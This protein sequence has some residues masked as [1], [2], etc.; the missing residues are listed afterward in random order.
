MRT[1]G[2]LGR[3]AYLWGVLFA[4]ALSCSTLAQ[5]ILGPDQMDPCERATF[6]ITVTNQ[7]A[8]QD[9][10]LVRITRSYTESGVLY[11][12]GSTTILLH[13][14]TELTADP[15]AS[16]WDIDALLGSAYTLPPA[17][18]ITIAYDLETS[19]AAV[20][21]TEQ[22]TV[23]YED[24][25][26]P[27]VSLQGVSSTSIEI[28]P[29]AVT[30]TKSPSVQDASVGE[31]VTWTITVDSTGLG[32]VSNVEVTDVLGSGLA[33]VSDTA[34]GSNDGQ[35][36]TW[37]LGDIPAGGST[38]FELTAEVVA[39]T[40][41]INEAD[42]R[43]GCSPSDI[44][45]DSSDPEIC[46]CPPA[47]AS[48]NLIVKNPALSFTAPNVEVGY[49][50]NETVGTIQLTNSGDGW[51]RNGELCC[52]VAYLQVDP[53]RLPP[54]TTYS[55]GC[56]QLPDIAPNST[57]DLTF[58]VLHS[59]VDW[60]NGPLPSGD[61]VFQLNYTNDCGIPFVAFPQF[62]TL[63]SESGPSL[64]VAKTGPD[65]LRLGETGSYD[66]TVMYFGSVDCGGGSPGLVTIVDSYPE[67][68]I[69]LD[70]AG[71][72]VDE[73]ARTISW[74]YDPT[75]DQPFEGTVQLEAPIDCSYCA[76]PSGGSDPNL[77]T[78]V[79]T[80][81]CGCTIVGTASAETTILCEGFGDD[82]E[83]FSSSMALDRSI[84]VRCSEDYAVTVTHTYTFIDDPA[85]DDLLLNEFTYFVDGNSNLVYSSGTASVTGAT[86]DTVVD[87]T[88]FGRL[89]LPLEDATTARGKTIVYEYTL[90]VQDLDS[91]SCQA[92][93]IP[94][95]AGVDLEIG[96]PELGLCGTMYPDPG[97]QISVTAQPPAMRV[98]LSG[99][100]E[101]QEACATYPVTITLERTSTIAQPYDVRL[102][103]S[104]NG[105]SIITPSEAACDGSVSPITSCTNPSEAGSTYEWLFGDSFELA[106]DVSTL[107]VPVT[108]PCSGSLAD[109]SAAV[110][111]DDLCHNDA[112]YD[113]SCSASTSDQALLSLEANVFTRKSP[114]LLY[115]S[116]RS[117]AWT[118]VVQNTG[119]ASAHNVWVDDIMGSGLSFDEANTN[120][121]G[122]T[123]TP[124]QDHLGNA[125][126]G[127]TF[128][129]SEVAPGQVITMTVGA[130]L[131]DCDGLTNDIEVSWGCA[132]E[133]C[134][135]PRTDSSSALV[136]GA[137]V[138]ATSF[139]PTPV[140]MC[141]ESTATVTVKSSGIGNAYNLTGEV[142]LP[143]GLVYLG[144]PQVRIGNGA[145]TPTSDP[146]GIPGPNLLWTANEIS[147]LGE[148]P[149]GT[150]IDIRFDFTV[151]C[152]FDG[153][154]L[155]FRSDYE[156]PC[157][158]PFSS[159]VGQFAIS[160]IPADLDVTLRQVSPAAGEALDCGGAATWEIDVRNVGSVA[161]P[162]AQVEAILGDGLAYVSST[163]DPTYGPADGGSNVGQSVSWEIV[164][165]PVDAV[166]TLDVTAF[167]T[168]GGLD[169]EALDIDVDA[170]WGCGNVD[171]LSTTF[172]ADCT[173]TFPSSS[174]I[175]GVREPPLD[176]TAS[177]SPDTIEACSST[178]TMTLTIQ[179]SSAVAT[180]SDVDFLITLPDELSYVSGSS[181]IDC[182]SGFS[183]ASNPNINGQTLSW[184]NI[185]AEGV[186]NDGCESI[187]PGGTI[188]L[189]FDANISCYF[190][191]QN[192][193][194]T[195]YYYDCCGLTQ[196]DSS[197]SATL[198]SLL[199]S[200]TVDKSPVNPN[201]DCYDAGD[202]V[203]WTLTVTNTGTGV[204]DWIRLEDT[205]GS[206]LVVDAFTDLVDETPS[207]VASGSQVGQTITWEADAGLAP[208][209][210]LSA[211][212]TAY[213]IQ[214]SDD[215]SQ[216]LRRNTAIASWG[217]GTFA[218]PACTYETTVQDI[219][220]VR[221]PNLTINAGDIEPIF[222]CTGD[223]I[224]PGSGSIQITVRNQGSGDAPI[225]E[226]FTITIAEP[227]TGF[228]VSDT[229]VGLG[230][231]LPLNDDSSQTIT[232]EG[233]D[234]A[235]A[236]C[237]Y[238][239]TVAL[240]M[241]DTIC[242]CQETDNMATLNGTITLPD[243]TIDSAALSATCAGDNQIHI[244]GPVTLRNDGCG[245]SL[246]GDVLMRFR[247]FDGAN[248]TGSEID[249]FTVNFAGLSIAANGGTDQE[250]INVVRTLAVCNLPD[251]QLSIQIEADDGDAVCECDGSNNT[252]C[253][254][255][256][257]IDFPD[258]TVADIDFSNLSCSNDAM[259]GFARVT[260]ENAG[261]GDAGAFVLRLATDGCL[262]FSDENV[263]GLTAGSTTTV[264]FA[265]SSAWADCADCTCAFTATI[266][267]E[268]EICE[269]DGTNNSASA[270][271]TSP[272]PDLEISGVVGSIGCAADGQGTV[273][274]DVT[275][276]NTGCADVTASFDL[277]VTLY[278]G[279]N[280]TG[281]VIDSW[282]ETITGETIPAS[283]STVI[284]LT[285]RLLTQALCAGDCEYSAHFEVDAGNDI[286]EC[287]GTDNEFCLSSIVSEVP[288]L[289]VTEVDPQVDCQ[290]GTATVTA[291]VGNTG[292]GDATGVVFR[293]TSSG[294]APTADSAPIDLAAGTSQDI[295]FSYTPDC[296]DWNCAF[297]VTADP[298]NAICECDGANTLTLDPYPGIGSIGDRVWFD[299]DGAGD[300]D[301]TEE[302]IANV[303]VILEADLDGDGITD[304]TAE[305]TTDSD[306]G[307]LFDELPAGDYTITVD[308]TTL[309]DGMG[310]TYDYDGLGTPHTSDYTLAEN[311]HNQEQDFGYRGLGSIG[312]L[313]WFDA[314]G[315]GAQDPS[316]EGIENVTLTLEGDV[317]GDGVDEIFTTTTDADGLYLF[318]F[319]PAG[320]YTI[321]VDHT[322]L[323]E[324]LSQTYDYDGLGSP[325]TSDYSLAAG[326]D[327]R[328]QDFGYATPAL[329]V[330]KVITDIL[331]E[332]ASIGSNTGPV[333]PGDVIVYE[334]VIENVGPVPA[335]NVGFDDTLPA[336][337][338]SET[339][340]PGN[341]GSY[342]VSD[343]AASG[344]LGL[345]DD[346]DSFN[347]PL[348]LTVNAGETL[349]ASFTGIVTSSVQQGDGLTNTARAYGEAEDG[350]PIP[351]E[352]VLLG[353]T[354]DS[355]VEDPDADDTGIVT[356]S[357]V[358]PALSVDKTITDIVRPGVGSLGIGG[359]VEPGDTVSYRFV[360]TNVGGA[361]AYDVEFTDTLPPGMETLAGGTYV[362]SAPAS[363][364]SL[365][366]AAGNPSFSTAINA[367]LSGGATLTADFDA[368][369]TSRIEQGVD[370]VNTAEASGID[371]FGSEI[372]DENTSAG[373]TSDTDV[374]DPDADDVGIAIIG[375]EEPA[376]SVDKIITDILRGGSSIGNTGPVEPGD[377]VF[378]QY[379]ITNVGLGTAYDVDFVD[380]L[381]AG[382][383]IETDAPGDAGSYV[384]SAP[385]ASGTL[386]LVDGAGFFGTS[387]NVV[388]AGGET[389]TANYTVLVTSDIDQ[390]TDLINVAATTGIDGAGNP[391]PG[392]NTDVDDTS[393][394][395]AEDPDA[396]DTGITVLATREPALSIDKQITEIIRGG[397]SIGL[398]DPLV[399]SDIIVYTVAIRNVGLG[400]AYGVEFAD[401][402]P[403]GLV[404][405][406]QSPGNAGNYIVTSP[407]AS[408][409]LAVPDG[410]GTF[411]TSIDATINAGESL[412]AT[413]TVLVTP[414]APQAQD[415]VNTASTWGLDG[416]GVP[417][418]ESN[419]ATGDTSDDDAE[420]PDADDTGIAII[421]VGIPALVTDKSIANVIRDGQSLGASSTVQVGDTIVYNLLI[422]NVGTA[423]A[424]DVD[425]RD[426]LPVQFA[427]V[428]D[429]TTASWPYRIGTYTRDPSG[430][431]GPT[432][433]WNTN[434][435][436]APNDVLILRFKATVE[437]PVSP[438]VDYTNV[439]QATGVDAVGVPI[440]PNQSD[441]VPEDTD[442]D[443]RDEV[444]VTA[445]G[446]TPALVTAKRV[447]SVIRNG[448]AV[449]DS[450]IELADVIQ[451][452]I[453]VQNVGS[454]TAYRVDLSDR[455]PA[456]FAYQ[457]NTTTASWPSGSWF[458]DPQSLGGALNWPLQA[459]LRASE[460]I[461]LT[462]DALVQGPIYDASSYIN[463]MRAQGVDA[464]GAPIPPNQ[465]AQ[466]PAD[467]DPDDSS[468]A[469]LVARSAFIQGEGG[470]VAVPILRKTAEVIS[471]AG[472]GAW[473]VNADR[474]WFQTDI[475]MYAAF[476]FEQFADAETSSSLNA[477]TLLPTWILT[478]QV[479]ALNAAIQNVLQVNT[480]SPLGVPL[481]AGPRIQELAAAEGVSPTRALV[482]RLDRLSERA[483]LEGTPDATHW[484]V[485]EYEAGE[486]VFERA[487][488]AALGPSGDWTIQTKNIVASAL[489]MGLL[490]QATRSERL[491]ASPQPMDRYLGWVL[492]E[493][494]ANKLLALDEQL[495]LRASATDPFIPHRTTW[496]ASTNTYTVTDS[497]STLFD[498]LSL[499]WGLARVLQLAQTSATAWTDTE[500]DLQTLVIE[501]AQR[502]LHDAL[503]RIERV[504]AADD[505]GWQR[506]SDSNVPARTTELGLLLAALEDAEAAAPDQSERISR[507]A[508]LAGDTL[509][510]RQHVDGQFSELPD[511][512]PAVHQLLSQAAGLRGLMA[513]A[514]LLGLQD[515][516]EAAIRAFHAL[517]NGLWREGVAA[518]IYA[519]QSIEGADRFCYTPLELGVTV[520]ALRELASHTDNEISD[521]AY[522]RAGALLRTV[523]DAAALQLSNAQ[524]QD[525]SII[526][527]SGYGDLLGLNLPEDGAQLVPVMQQ[528]LCI[529]VEPSEAPCGGWR[530]PE[531]DPWYQTD[532]SMLAG[533]V[534]QDR[535]PTREDYADA[536][537]I[538]ATLHSELGIPFASQL[539]LETLLS[540]FSQDLFLDPQLSPVGI[541][542]AAGDPSLD[543]TATPPFR[544]APSGFDT[545]ILASALG[546]T[547]LRQAQEVREWLATENPSPE[548][549][550]VARLLTAA[551]LENITVLRQLRIPGPMN[552]SYIPTAV[553][554]TPSPTA[555]WS[556]LEDD[557]TLFG[558]SS[559]LWGL[560]EA[561][562]LF[563]DPAIQPLLNLQPFVAANWTAAIADLADTVLQTL[564]TALLDNTWNVLVDQAVP[565]STQWRLGDLVST[566]NVGL[567]TAALEHAIGTFGQSSDLG[568]R[569]LALLQTELDFLHEVLQDPRGFF[570]E[571]WTRALGVPTRAC[572]E[573]TLTSQ[574][575]GV[576]GLLSE[577]AANGIDLDTLTSIFRGIEARFWNGSLGL[578]AQRYDSFEWCVTPLDLAIFVDTFDRMRLLVPFDR[579]LENRFERHLDRML[580]A[581]SLQLQ[582][583]RLSEQAADGALDRYAPVFDRRVCIEPSKPIGGSRWANPG[584]TVRYEIQ[585]ENITDVPFRNLVLTD[586]LP[587]GVRFMSSEPPA[588][589][590][591]GRSI[592]WLADALAPNEERIWQVLAQVENSAQSQELLQNCATLTYT[593]VAGEPQPEREACADIQISTAADAQARV[594]DT[595]PVRYITDEAMR[596]AA[597]LA[598]LACD[599]TWLGS[600]QAEN[601]ASTNLGILLQASS[602]GV[603]FVDAPGFTHG[604]LSSLAANVG[605]TKVPNLD[606]LICLPSI[607]GIPVLEEGRG[608]EATDSNISPAALGW[609]LANEAQYVEACHQPPTALSRF[610]E[611]LNLLIVAQ[612]LDWISTQLA[613]S[614]AGTYYLPHRIQAV[615]TQEG[616]VFRALD[617][618]S[619]IYDQ[620][621][622]L[623]GLLAVSASD[624][625]DTRTQRLADQ[626]A[627]GTFDH[628]VQHWDAVSLQFS[629][630]VGGD[631]DALPASWKDVGVLALSLRAVRTQLPLRRI[632]ADNLLQALAQ[633]AIGQ[634]PLLEQEAEANRLLV[635]LVAYSVASKDELLQDA[636]N[637][638]EHL[639]NS[640]MDPMASAFYVSIQAQRGWA[641]TPRQIAVL[642][643]VLAEL[644]A[645][646]P[647]GTSPYLQ[648]AI[649]LLGQDVRAARVQLLA[650]TQLWQTHATTLC[651]GLAPVFGV[652][653][654][655]LPDWLYR[656][657]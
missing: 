587:T 290:A 45:F 210:S 497:G 321:T 124:N 338:V 575:A 254:G 551:I 563:E 346:V 510:E 619:W 429:S 611:Q 223:G 157:G 114:E 312:D 82:I 253:V 23:D 26:D 319:L 302:G 141:S 577:H 238:A 132:G 612:Q 229:F 379:T 452:E 529:E 522:A 569:A 284:S 455:L 269:C 283:S 234:V 27:G 4:I 564:E 507:L 60:C 178:T 33:Y 41:L 394:G 146:S 209:A 407:A 419:T 256:F 228:S 487:A 490:E 481:T 100:P 69:V 514:A 516:S 168:S 208:G 456:E 433:I 558:Q 286:C 535:T 489:G 263:A 272:L 533:Y 428:R 337:I 656:L 277:A 96:A 10:C 184:Y 288:N 408:G 488:D 370:L 24:C 630:T 570:H 457:G 205:L 559:L 399:Y 636:R 340:A 539:H 3:P 641:H 609:T 425:V 278:G 596:L 172:D 242:E 101:I 406:T 163:G 450:R 212:V 125:I 439:L 625:F 588:D 143:E 594:L 37:S 102:V 155:A 486:P 462:Y 128:L 145:W 427:Y 121:S 396:D 152:S 418:P 482:D 160:L 471:E 553:T 298:S 532:I 520:G 53:T 133:N 332:D 200:L 47:T 67:G 154:T 13:D 274:A 89:E 1:R 477:E 56:F 608:F 467:I 579:I 49:C 639:W 323:P 260:V 127:A 79:G 546:T 530:V 491:L 139:S 75:I 657:P 470:L 231:T 349:T 547:L 39:C 64:Q 503:V 6:T 167:A 593:D 385:A 380:T 130:E 106:D 492:V 103:L 499:I 222:S 589:V 11:V 421:R 600:D 618:S 336:G 81:C 614:E 638:W 398:V 42:V 411:A 55:N 599:H 504:H 571:Q 16:S 357:V 544:W 255:T 206:S 257:P 550:L 244:Q 635:M 567:A 548:D 430:G 174:T 86:L 245:D 297:T 80:D 622:L 29:G 273:D 445:V 271:F 392:E 626:L 322:T 448:I 156:N 225:T 177:L 40:G 59:E 161:I 353:D 301:P 105:G 431:A 474:L 299:L 149:P 632:E 175:S 384:V 555:P 241:T 500:S 461:T 583:R 436:L 363:S 126:N 52:Q 17:E 621:S 111:F 73:N 268:N 592:Q 449:S 15:T 403:T 153:G 417:I 542:Y 326:E 292:C 432:L 524:G 582:E 88:P 652:W 568:V 84:A 494:I 246:N 545:R 537:L 306:G 129:F 422:T 356:V 339:D 308:E 213:A 454:G 401:A 314:N 367:E 393:D 327:N 311:E 434:A 251:C 78:A 94:I 250:T 61:N 201:L 236:N 389:L 515:P 295:L 348:N 107:T 289:V 607:E 5:E 404:T 523:L 324:G 233:W 51:A 508:S 360:I 261:C 627:E 463:V 300:Q 77:V 147:A 412:T 71:G 36:T 188:R 293:L 343:P 413:Y 424:L 275:V 166:A 362:V 173:T 131:V 197:T 117:V 517:E 83:Y 30:I 134:Q 501:T 416:A 48:L 196:Y 496:N 95:Q 74:S 511:G 400:T 368:L 493:A 513:R 193:P 194:V 355:D 220:I 651:N 423:D 617:S 437:G 315:D 527:G 216:S 602:L 307:Y 397:E 142:A 169:C 469:V 305:T 187:P 453:T 219:S 50:T 279:A 148:V 358:I 119:N 565:A 325:H 217:C 32:T 294:C 266:D 479:E 442:P 248:C 92:S 120:P 634:S 506:R 440:P 615:E 655:T 98:N 485:L 584:D 182:G 270:P 46:G 112:I 2:Q 63:S 224:T 14:A 409:S 581:V 239:I 115:A 202:T 65:S 144:N 552:T 214:P 369:V 123:I 164:D 350:T 359:P 72:T 181:E 195:V 180:T 554:W 186:G 12:P 28:L 591:N 7:S 521:L 330:D 232:V 573:E 648:D 313:V 495:T 536:N 633:M 556:A 331:R 459:T 159:N 265:I 464:V 534:L 19:C 478:G 287:D 291:T 185:N 21:G 113:D 395:D 150:T 140:A 585:A 644:M 252:Y 374:E 354:S 158:D 110:F 70:P 386:G 414:S 613:P 190:T 382:M 99:I 557:T 620:A 264:D 475:A 329:S 191:T 566:Q 402:L 215:C 207:F 371:G 226:D 54:G 9:A 509:L 310:Q 574:L 235:C 361:T 18:S 347:V 179:N 230:G 543:A 438:G 162:V 345:S 572:A 341:A 643:E 502:L 649:Q 316:E 218:A 480:L 227:N 249:T 276:E 335:Y 170:A 318:D 351:E 203:T 304:Y 531:H 8:T 387:L 640:I 628:L 377:I 647:D 410:V 237:G 87:N 610:L 43:W 435:T 605:L 122:A 31:E 262:T 58:Y 221:V 441:D 642:F 561:Y 68:F 375:T 366:I 631:F 483:G 258:L 528:Q 390:G 57:F 303:T 645:M 540:E 606:S 333:E 512:D 116:E 34:S 135:T 578:Y 281:D 381:P 204:A 637:N 624:R 623:H 108:I 443:D 653:E 650:P 97:N 526:F 426:S 91:P 199:P 35:T 352:N 183:P 171:G 597:S 586:L 598:A 364:G 342:V 378:Y 317:D 560:S 446:D 576:R 447:R 296:E 383:V 538:A 85:L 240:D 549:T 282:T 259:S 285:Q 44:C 176:L 118:V 654:G 590:V 460:H 165:L 280:C 468:Q 451:Y 76:G 247:I 138:V 25:E 243:L 603:P 466:I 328:D 498:Q 473:N 344:S 519:T 601:L 62:S 562:R 444:S 93:T 372:P 267:P 415:L 198:T 109:L 90:I 376:L 22:V 391:I 66:I 484:I 604:S 518:G 541:P 192:I 211:T 151:L 472:C 616:M 320:N 365:S 580:D 629:Q 595:T 476:E 525:A 20:S 189:R 646:H 136:P 458:S 373:D 137:Q 388:I 104:N 334:F 405:E 38:S 465:S 309:P 505:S 420:D